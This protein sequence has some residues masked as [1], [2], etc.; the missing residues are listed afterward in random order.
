MTLP[1]WPDHGIH[2]HMLCDVALH[3]CWTCLDCPGERHARIAARKES[4]PKGA[5][6]HTLAASLVIKCAV[7]LHYIKPEIGALH[8]S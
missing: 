8:C 1:L 7:A 4:L 6:F 2:T 5:I 3:D